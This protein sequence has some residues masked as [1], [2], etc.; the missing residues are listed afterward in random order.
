MTAPPTLLPFPPPDTTM[1]WIAVLGLM[2]TA[3]AAKIFFA[4]GCNTNADEP[5][6]W[7]SSGVS[8]TGSTVP[9]GSQAASGIQFSDAA[10]VDMHFSAGN[11]AL[12]SMEVRDGF[13]ITLSHGSAINILGDSASGPVAVFTA[14][15]SYKAECDILCHQNYRDGNLEDQDAVATLPVSTTPIAVSDHLIFPSG[16]NYAAEAHGALLAAAAI[17]WKGTTITSGALTAASCLEI[18]P[19]VTSQ[20]FSLASATGPAASTAFSA[21]YGTTAQQSMTSCPAAPVPDAQD[22]TTLTLPRAELQ[23]MNLRRLGTQVSAGAR[24]RAMAAPSLGMWGDCPHINRIMCIENGYTLGSSNQ[25]AANQTA[26]NQTVP[27]VYNNE[28]MTVELTG[29]RPRADLAAMAQPAQRIALTSHINA[30]LYQH[31]REVGNVTIDSAMYGSHTHMQLRLTL[32]SRVRADAGA[33]MRP[34]VQ[35]LQQLVSSYNV[36]PFGCA[37]VVEDINFGCV[38]QEMQLAF[39]RAYNG[40]NTMLQIQ[41]SLRAAYGPARG[42]SVSELIV[43]NCTANFTAPELGQQELLFRDMMVSTII[44]GSTT[45]APTVAPTPK[46]SA[47]AGGDVVE[48]NVGLPLMFIVIILAVLVIAIALFISCRGRGKKSGYD[49]EAGQHRKV[50]V[51]DNP[52]YDTKSRAN[53]IADIDIGSP[54]DIYDEPQYVGD[55]GVTAA[56]YNDIQGDSDDGDDDDD[57]GHFDDATTDVGYLDVTKTEEVADGNTGASDVDHGSESDSS[58]EN[59]DHKSEQEVNN[60]TDDNYLNVAENEEAAEE[61]IADELEGDDD[62]DDDSDDDDIDDSDDA[63]DLDE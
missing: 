30:W 17:T 4:P 58:I 31:F 23:Q 6:N 41:S 14:G 42:C 35:A 13:K 63:S 3:R 39:A 16:Y 33:Y 22:V 15:Q 51:F 38:R 47:A 48:D 11:Y 29:M 46:V 55:T 10:P 56:A 25:T 27:V 32:S 59:D 49:E 57:E 45:S 7:A 43:G 21:L 37:S 1:L 28:S 9:T 44:Q 52:M 12:G 26:L 54:D 60:V 36:A 61:I 20:P 50:A 18:N 53:P 34:L 40:Q 62:S 5:S 2:G 24:L 19:C 8:Y